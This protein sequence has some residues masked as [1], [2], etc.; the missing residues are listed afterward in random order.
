MMM[1]R[2][3][4]PAVAPPPQMCHVSM[5]VRKL[6]PAI[7][8]LCGVDVDTVGDNDVDSV[9]LDFRG[10]AI[11]GSNFLTTTATCCTYCIRRT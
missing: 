9:D 6:E 10:G 3:F 4:G 11:A 5:A 1:V 7:A 2:K 8:S